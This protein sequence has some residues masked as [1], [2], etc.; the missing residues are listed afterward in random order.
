MKKIH[1]AFLIAVLAC[2]AIVLGASAQTNQ[3]TLKMSRDW[4]YGG[5]SGDIQGLFTMRVTGPADLAKV[6]F[7]IDDQLIGEVMQPPFNL[8]FNTDDYPLGVHKL[9]AKGV[10][11]GGQEYT[12]NVLSAE[13]VPASRAGKTVLP[14]LGGLLVVVL[15]AALVPLV[16]SRKIRNLPMGAERKYGAAGGVI[17]PRCKRPFPLSF[18][19]PNMGFSKLAI[20]P[21]CRKVSLLRPQPLEKLREAERAELSGE[22]TALPETSEAERLKKELDDSK[23]Q[24]F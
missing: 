3:L 14:L 13:F 4:G 10:S 7:Y 20:C 9:S 24:G 22:Q 18:L 8:Q 11:S 6:T 23:F 21:Y 5:F 1:I 16:F 12:S 15:L 19:S 17:C 2:F